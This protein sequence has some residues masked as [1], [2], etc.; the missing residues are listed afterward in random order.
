MNKQ[1][2]LRGFNKYGRMKSALF[3]NITQCMVLILTHVS[4]QPIGQE[5]QDES[6]VHRFLD[7]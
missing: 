3:W 6:S 5:I 7:H 1:K 4:A 2:G